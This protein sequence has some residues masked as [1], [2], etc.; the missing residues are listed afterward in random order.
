MVTGVSSAPRFADV[1]YAMGCMQRFIC[2]GLP[3]CWT[4]D[5]YG[6]NRFTNT[7][8]GILTGSK[9]TSQMSSAAIC[10]ITKDVYSFKRCRGER[11]L[12]ECLIQRH[13]EKRSNVIVWGAIRYHMRSHLLQISLTLNSQR[14]IMKVIECEVILVLQRIRGFLFYQNNARSSCS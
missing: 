2:A 14:Y 5:S 8:G 12:L 11:L 6:C 3:C 13:T 7:I 4:T 9:S 10:T 1:C